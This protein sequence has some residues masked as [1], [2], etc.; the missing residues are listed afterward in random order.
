MAEVPAPA[1]A[2]A[3]APAPSVVPRNS[4]VSRMKKKNRLERVDADLA[5]ARAAIRKAILTRNVTSEDSRDQD[6]IP[7]G[8]VYR[9]AYAFHQS[10]IEMVKK[11]KIWA[12][13]EGERP[14]V[15]SGP[16]K[17]IYAIEGQF[18]DEME[19]GKSP[20]LARYP[21]EAHAF[22]I[23]MSIQHIVEYIY[24]PITTYDR[25]RLIR[26]FKDYI[27]VVANK[28]PYWNASKG[29]D[30]FMLSCHDW[31]PGITAEDP[32]LYKNLIR[33]LCNANTSEGF[34]P[35]RDV[36]LPEFNIP[37]QSLTQRWFSQ[38]PQNRST[39]AFFA[40]GV[41][42]Y[43]R[44]VLISQWEGKDNDVRVHEY[45]PKGEDYA[46]LLGDSKY[47]LCPSGYEVAS[48]RLVETFHA[49]CVPV[50]I[51]DH[52][53]LPFSDVLDWG[54]FSVTIP[55]EKIPEIKKI[56]LGISESKYLEMQTRVVKLRR[57]F[58]LNRPPMP[59]DAL[60]MVLHSIWLRRLNMRIPMLD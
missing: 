38:P 37:P 17:H 43:I 55:V 59:F 33:V 47:C 60:H 41:H 48:P 58:T 44:K 9:N 15:H 13:R 40:G 31:A 36:A 12:Y 24:M 35:S 45:L 28:Y 52:Y 4:V 34:Q 50:I 10:H 21:E 14:L 3:P 39:L 51:S 20:F 7:R 5:Q 42:G 22:F 19:N 49:G 57:H 27:M 56:L 25:D 2:A 46:K 54:N 16:M 53:S 29:A 26:I 6:F 1:L 11:F 23:P 8:S 30:H 18:I 32:E